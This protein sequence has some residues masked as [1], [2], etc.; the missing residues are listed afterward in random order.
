MDTDLT[1]LGID[2]QL[3]SDSQ[4]F[5]LQRFLEQAFD[6]LC[7]C[8]GIKRYADELYNRGK[9]CTEEYNNVYTLFL[10]NRELLVYALENSQ[11][12]CHGIPFQFWA[13]WRWECQLVGVVLKYKFAHQALTDEQ[14]EKFPCVWE[15]IGRTYGYITVIIEQFNV[16]RPGVT[17]YSQSTPVVP[18]PQALSNHQ[19]PLQTLSWDAHGR[20]IVQPEV[21][22]QSEIPTAVQ[23]TPIRTVHVEAASPDPV[24]TVHVQAAPQPHSQ[25]WMLHH[26]HMLH[27][28]AL[29]TLPM[30]RQC[31]TEL[32]MFPCS[33]PNVT[34]QWLLV[35]L[36]PRQVWALHRLCLTGQDIRGAMSQMCW[37]AMVQFVGPPHGRG[38]CLWS[39]RQAEKLRNCGMFS[40]DLIGNKYFMQLK[41]AR[42]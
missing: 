26:N 32:Q 13:M 20:L 33:V 6:H 39:R 11:K 36:Y 24:R 10:Q 30:R 21:L 8:Q 16:V 5:W 42:A 35:R 18:L 28:T 41:R 15:N 34:V 9:H 1:T 19:Q 40:E 12:N 23:A 7:K 17:Q 31:R 3:L 27:H 4:L 29:C 22:T 37:K 38:S 2:P 25:L 14:R